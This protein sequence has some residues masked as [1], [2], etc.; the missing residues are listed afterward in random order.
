MLIGMLMPMGM[1]LL[2]LLLVM[3]M[4]SDHVCVLMDG[5][6]CVEI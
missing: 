4:S 3:L 5:C 1:L 6:A 2:L